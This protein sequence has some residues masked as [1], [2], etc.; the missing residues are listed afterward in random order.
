MG[1]YLWDYYRGYE[2]D[3]RSLDYGSDELSQRNGFSLK[4]LYRSKV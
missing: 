3:M 1:D 2:G 4:R